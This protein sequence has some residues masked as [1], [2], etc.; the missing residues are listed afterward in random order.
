[1]GALVFV[2]KNSPSVLNIVLTIRLITACLII[3]HV[4]SHV[5]LAF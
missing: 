4:L 1:M 5:F 2:V 3:F